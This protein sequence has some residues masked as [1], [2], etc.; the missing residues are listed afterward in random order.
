MSL[1]FPRNRFVVV[2]AVRHR[3]M[4]VETS[5]FAMAVV[6]VASIPRR[7]IATRRVGGD[8]W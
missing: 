5:E 2:V 3:A 1:S 8:S 6:G 4:S 7:V